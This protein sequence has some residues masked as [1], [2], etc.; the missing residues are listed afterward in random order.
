MSSNTANYVFRLLARLFGFSQECE[1]EQEKQEEQQE[2]QQDEEQTEG[3]TDKEEEETNDEGG[4][5]H[6]EESEDSSEETTEDSSEEDNTDNGGEGE[7]ESQDDSEAEPEPEV[8]H[9]E[10]E[11]MDIDYEFHPKKRVEAPHEGEGAETIEVS[12]YHREG[13]DLGLQ[14]CRQSAPYVNYAFEEAWGD[15]YRVDVT[16]VEE[17]VPADIETMDDWHDHFWHEAPPETRSKDANC[18]IFDSDS[19]SGLGGG[20]LAVVNGPDYF[21]D[22]D[23]DPDERPFLFGSG[24]GHEGVN[25]VVHEVGHCLGLPHDGD[26]I[27]KYG[28]SYIPIM[29]TSYEDG[30][31]F[32]HELHR[33][34]RR[35]KP[36]VNDEDI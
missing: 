2:E 18:L 22:F 21:E 5:D 4:H 24:D 33:V 29:R 25:R 36:K 15:D 23:Y 13:D 16:V 14:S 10:D 8:N 30:N 7:E 11:S 3:D 6:G 32:L 28:K 26:K 27:E 20:Y 34:N 1:C 12:L 31:H 17:P 19:V 35:K 9:S